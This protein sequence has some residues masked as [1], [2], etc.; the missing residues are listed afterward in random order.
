MKLLKGG[1]FIGLVVLIVVTAQSLY[2]Y[3]Y[4]DPYI[5]TKEKLLNFKDQGIIL[6]DRNN[7]PFYFI[8]NA[9][10]DEYVSLKD[11]SP[12]LPK[13][14]IAAEDRTFYSHNGI[15]LRGMLRSVILN[16][17]AGGFAY[18]GSTI[19]QQLVKNTLL[20]PKKS[21]IRKGQEAILAFNIESKYSKDEILEMYMNSVYFGE[22]AIGIKDAANIY[23]SKNP[24][25]LTAG[26]AAYLAGMLKF[27]SL[28]SPYSGDK[29]L[30]VSIK[31]E[32]LG[33]MAESG[34]ITHDEAEASR[35]TEIVFRRGNDG[36][37]NEAPHFA[38]MVVDKLKELYGSDVVYEGL[39]VKTS[40]DLE[41]Q[42]FAQNVVKERVT[43]N[44]MNGVS[45]GAVVAMDPTTGEV[46]A[47]VGS[48]DWFDER[49][50]KVNMATTPRQPG[51]SFKPLVYSLAMDNGI[52]TPATVLQDKPKT[53]VL[54]S[55]CRQRD[56]ECTY[57][58]LNYD[59]KFRGPVT[60]RRSLA[61][62]LN[63]PSVEIMNRLGIDTLLMK[64]P[65]FGISTLKDAT[66]YGKG[67]SLA[68]G[69]AEVSP[70]EMTAAYS[71][72][73]N[74]GNRPEPLMILEIKDKFGKIKYQGK[75]SSQNVISEETAYLINSI[76][77]DNNTRSET[78][79]SLLTTPFPAA[80]KTGT[81]ENYRDA[82]TIGYTPGLVVSVWVGNNDAK[83]IYNLPG[84]LAAAPIWKAIIGEYASRRPYLVFEK[85]SGIIA[86]RYCDS[87]A[88]GSSRLEYFRNGTQPRRDCIPRTP[89]DKEVAG[90]DERLPQIGGEAPNAE[91]A[92]AENAA[93]NIEVMEDKRDKDEEK[94]EDEQNSIDQHQESPLQPL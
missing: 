8:N 94:K 76:L 33:K 91:T 6:S 62:S 77:S 47:L 84:S 42:Q 17:K 14:I 3:L 82:W 2:T 56:N 10:S 45:N 13:A 75:P 73:A 52:I 66:Y 86:A 89:V 27:P 15:S 21:L 31:N 48:A 11:V 22:G 88:S 37:T 51:S 12:Y 92:I 25:D 16:V 64:A 79:G 5:Q 83:P 90:N 35:N 54:D 40:L 30:G 34:Q 78:F 71:T 24:K 87:S 23:F 63:V 59:K 9:V 58:P 43:Q 53:F 69:S 44:R 81:T 93:Q 49:S 57:K 29:A 39:K 60:V 26:E 61:N 72:F 4:Y 46:L 41:L 68:L 32:V 85:P 1:G 28:I 70:L 20:S 50:G 74:N 18:G 80:V 55:G 38:L 7:T 65:A 36:S 19:T 67:L